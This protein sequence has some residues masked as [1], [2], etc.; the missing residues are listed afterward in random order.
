MGNSVGA[1]LTGPDRAV[2]TGELRKR[3]M[4]QGLVW[5]IS[6]L[7][8]AV[9]GVKYELKEALADLNNLD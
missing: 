2:F 9:P 8:P 6:I 3:L 5:E 4:Q 7:S 1:Q